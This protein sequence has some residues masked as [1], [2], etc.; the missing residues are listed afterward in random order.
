[1]NTAT[2]TTTSTTTSTLISTQ[3]SVF[4]TVANDIVSTTTTS[5]STVYINHFDVAPT[6]ANNAKRGTN[7]RQAYPECP[8]E[9]KNIALDVATRACE[10]FLPPPQTKTIIAQITST[11]TNIVTALSTT[12]QT[13]PSLTSTLTSTVIV[14][15]QVD[16]TTTVTSTY[17]A[18]GT[19]TIFATTTSTTT[20]TS[21]IT[22][23][24]TATQTATVTSHWAKEYEDTGTN[25]RTYNR[26]T[27]YITIPEDIRLDRGAAN[28]FCAN[29]CASRSACQFYDFIQDDPAFRNQGDNSAFCVL[30]NQSGTGSQEQN[31]PFLLYSLAYNRISRVVTLS[32]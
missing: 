31:V 16:Q 1:M 30:D 11:S 2:V 18:T 22:S 12:T 5:T 13:V 10:C 21:S 14:A 17:L 15:T 7:L 8:E 3:T 28:T 9:L 6:A 26:Y 19:S 23:T 25:A 20:S 4:T 27:D 32:E 29:Q 24:A